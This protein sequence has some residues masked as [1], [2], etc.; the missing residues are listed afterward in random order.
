MR[1]FPARLPDGFSKHSGVSRGQRLLSMPQ[2]DQWESGASLR[3]KHPPLRTRREVVLDG[4]LLG[5]NQ[6]TIFSSSLFVL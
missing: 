1:R 2:V 3:V 5:A 4:L 6:T